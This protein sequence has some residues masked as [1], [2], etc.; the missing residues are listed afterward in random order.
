MGSEQSPFAMSGV[1]LGLSPIWTFHLLCVC[2]GGWHP[3]VRDR[4]G[5]HPKGTRTMREFDIKPRHLTLHSNVIKLCPKVSQGRQSLL[6]DVIAVYQLTPMYDKSTLYKQLETPRESRTD[7]SPDLVEKF[8]LVMIYNQ[9]QLCQHYPNQISQP[10]RHYTNQS[11]IVTP[12]S[13]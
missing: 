10:N 12:P 11:I 7:K 4:L 6:D 1:W 13:C 2:V 3:Q 8:R 9:N 5:G